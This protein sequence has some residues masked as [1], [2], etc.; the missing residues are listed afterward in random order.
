MPKVQGTQIDDVSTSIPIPFEGAQIAVSTVQAGGG[1]GY[2]SDYDVVL[3]SEVS[4]HGDTVNI[5][6][7]RSSGSSA[8]LPDMAEYVVGLLVM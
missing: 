4:P 6:I 3:R 1:D 2:Y 7:M 8:F 5:V